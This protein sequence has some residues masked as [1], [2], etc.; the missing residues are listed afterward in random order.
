M[1]DRIIVLWYTL[2]CLL[3]FVPGTGSG[4]LGALY[5]ALAVGAAM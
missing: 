4:M 2:S 5:P 3:G 1:A